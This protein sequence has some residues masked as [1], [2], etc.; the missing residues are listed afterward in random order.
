M[1]TLMAGLTSEDLVLILLV[2]WLVMNKKKENLE[3][4]IGLGFLLVIGLKERGAGDAGFLS[5]GAV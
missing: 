3:L 1:N 4:L 2:L 5:D